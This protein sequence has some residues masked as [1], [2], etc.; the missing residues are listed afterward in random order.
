MRPRHAFDGFESIGIFRIL[1]RIAT[2]S[3]KS[4]PGWCALPAD[5]F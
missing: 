4:N 5:T 2:G 3:E 1:V